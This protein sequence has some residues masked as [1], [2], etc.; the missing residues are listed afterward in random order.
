MATAL[1]LYNAPMPL[2]VGTESSGANTSTP[3]LPPGWAAGDWVAMLTNVGSGTGVATVTP[4]GDETWELGPG[5][6]LRLTTT[7][8][9]ATNP[10]TMYV[11]F[12]RLTAGAAAPTVTRSVAGD[13]IV[14]Q[15]FALRGV[16]HL[17]AAVDAIEAS[18]SDVATGGGTVNTLTFLDAVTTTPNTAYM[19]FATTGS[20]LATSAHGAITNAS[21]SF[22]AE[23][24][25]GGTTTGGGGTTYCAVGARYYTGAFAAGAPTCNPATGA[26][27][28]IRYAISVKSPPID[29]QPDLILDGEAV[30]APDLVV[31]YRTVRPPRIESA[32]TVYG[33]S[34]NVDYLTIRP[35]RIESGEIVFGGDVSQ[36]GDTTDPTITIL[37]PAPEDG[38]RPESIIR[39]QV[40]DDNGIGA[41]VIIAELLDED[42]DVFDEDVVHDGLNFGFRYRSTVNVA[43]GTEEDPQYVLN[44]RRDGGWTGS[45]RF[46]YVIRDTAG[47]AG[48]LA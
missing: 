32:E 30:Y 20:D 1:P 13:Y 3:G 10:H 4:G 38:V 41:L 31:D 48:V 12:C 17:G 5:M 28:Y 36:P 33:G 42:G 14:S 16:Y 2:G 44:V 35:F 9:N 26:V 24:I 37:E 43:E 45:P 25:D 46:R 40:D 29:A 7:G 23:K 47:R 22:L 11:H 6:P 19:M 39:L 34:L 27:Q 21:I 18:N 8:S 15:I